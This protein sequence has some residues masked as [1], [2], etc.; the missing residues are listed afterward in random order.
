MN[1]YFE[2]HAAA[3][4]AGGIE[5]ATVGLVVALAGEAMT[6]TR[7]FPDSPEARGPLPDCVHVHGIWSLA[8]MRHLAYW[9][10][11]GVPCVVSVH[12]MLEPWALAHKKWKKLVAWNVYQKR[13]LNQASALHATSEREAENL[14]KLGLNVP[15]VMIPWGVEMP[16]EAKGQAEEE[17]KDS[18][19]SLFPAETPTAQQ[20]RCAEPPATRTA[21]FVGRIYPVKGLPMLVEA[22]AKAR[23]VGWRMKIVGPDESGHQAEVEALVRKAGLEADFEFTGPLRGAALS[24]AYDAAELFILP[25][26]TENFSLVVGEALAHRVPVIAS[27]GTPWD[28]LVQER[29]GWWVPTSAFGIAEAL[30]EATRAEPDML[31][32]MGARGRSLI[33]S[34]F[35]WSSVAARFA[36]L[37][38]S[39]L[40]G[41]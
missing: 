30:Q 20:H 1:I 36:K 13:L 4:R 34:R 40:V 33:E 37:Y 5:A 28:V 26:Y 24:A 25:S 31:S 2:E 38:R 15:V 11:R 27:H 9:Q 18:A 16:G 14:K 32:E 35:S 39:T 6:V 29:C 12:G 3:Q 41:F 21:L 17:S 10:K 19:Q 8:L 7:H 22:W 23:P